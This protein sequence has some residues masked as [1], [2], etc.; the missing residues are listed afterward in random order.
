MKVSVCS[1]VNDG[2]FRLNVPL[3]PI[4]RSQIA[5]IWL[6]FRMKTAGKKHG[7]QTVC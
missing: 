7:K 3:L 4:A 6:I 1:N 2:N 5:S